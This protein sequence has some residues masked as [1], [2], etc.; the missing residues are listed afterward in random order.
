MLD[1][2]AARPSHH[3]RPVQ[4]R[5]R[6]RALE[7]QRCGPRSSAHRGPSGRLPDSAGWAVLEL[8]EGKTEPVA[9]CDT[10]S[11][12]VDA[13]VARVF[14]ENGPV[15]AAVRYTGSMTEPAA[16]ALARALAG[17]TQVGEAERYRVRPAVG[18]HRGTFSSGAFWWPASGSQPRCDPGLAP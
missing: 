8:A 7:A 12:A 16:D 13:M 14:A 17:L 6:K 9:A 1:S 3:A 4:G 10:I 15:S 18:A 5:A 11:E 2:N